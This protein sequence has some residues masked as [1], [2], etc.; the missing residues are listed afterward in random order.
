M[1]LSAAALSFLFFAAA[2]GFELQN[3]H[4]EPKMATEDLHFSQHSL[5][6]AADCCFNLI[7]QKIRCAFMEDYFE[8]S[9]G[10]PR[11]AVIFRTKKGKTVCADWRGKGVLDC[12]MSLKSR[13]QREWE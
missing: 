1:K 2:L 5:Y 8:T 4:H 3:I 7:K 10:C 11:S 12:M 13:K 9:S 6:S